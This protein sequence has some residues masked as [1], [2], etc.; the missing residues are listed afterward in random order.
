MIVNDTSSFIALIDFTVSTAQMHF[1]ENDLQAV[2]DDLLN[3]DAIL[4]AAPSS[5]N[6]TERDD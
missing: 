1:R 3:L 4:C 5:D 6:I 2:M